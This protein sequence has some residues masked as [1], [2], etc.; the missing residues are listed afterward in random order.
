MRKNSKLVQKLGYQFEDSS[1][2]EQA[3]SHRS[4]GKRNNE[5]LE[6]LGDS[7]LNFIIAESL[8]EKFPKACE[9]DLSRLRAS[10]VK[11]DTLAELAREFELGDFLLLGEGELKSGGFRRA[12]ILSDAVEALIGAIFKESGFEVCRSVVL[13]WFQSRLE[14]ISVDNTDK[15]PKTRLQ[16]Y[17]QEHKKDLPKYTVASIAGEA[18][19][20]QFEVSC[21]VSFCDEITCATASSKRTAEKL[22]A[23]K[24]LKIL[25]P[26]HSA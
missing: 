1:L 11:G 20:K 17:L 5:R 25:M 26:E 21:S 23:E 3:L 18:H 8:F 9:G 19:A 7:L 12:S 13:A 22:A 10:L 24:M 16:E 14:N 6:F 2:L 15:D 4:V